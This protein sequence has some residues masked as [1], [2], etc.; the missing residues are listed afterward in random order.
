MTITKR[1]TDKIRSE[2][3]KRIRVKLAEKGIKH[4][5]VAKKL[6]VT[7]PYFA[8]ILKGDETPS[9]KAILIIADILGLT[10]YELLYGI[11]CPQNLADMLL[12]QSEG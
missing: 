11:E 5:F 10:A 4:K 1:L 3:G 9:D 8:K 7:P 6:G 2:L 12:I